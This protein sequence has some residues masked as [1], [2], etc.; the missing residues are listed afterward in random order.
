MVIRS[1]YEFPES[2]DDIR[3]DILACP[4]PECKV[5]NPIL[6]H[7]ALVTGKHLYYVYCPA[8]QYHSPVCE[9]KEKAIDLHNQMCSKKGV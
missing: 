2:G 3:N 4:N 1:L 7:K 9:T 6:Y 5:T 8:C